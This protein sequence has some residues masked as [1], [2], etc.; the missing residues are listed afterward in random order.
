MTRNHAEQVGTDEWIKKA[1][2]LISLGSHRDGLYRD[3]LPCENN[4]KD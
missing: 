4:E 2:T 3:G 1:E